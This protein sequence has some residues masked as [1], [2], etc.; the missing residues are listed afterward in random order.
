M[1]ANAFKA[2][3]FNRKLMSRVKPSQ[4]ATFNDLLS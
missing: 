3:M 4:M 2:T 1:Y